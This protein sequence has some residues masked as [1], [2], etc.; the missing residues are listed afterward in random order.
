V[1][2]RPTPIQFSKSH[3]IFSSNGS[4]SQEGGW[5]ALLSEAMETITEAASSAGQYRGDLF[6][7][8]AVNGQ[9]A[10]ACFP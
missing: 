2:D 7:L 6:A 10:W 5:K 9:L 1:Q 3:I 8:G 4:A